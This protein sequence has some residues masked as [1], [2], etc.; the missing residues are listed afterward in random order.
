MTDYSS[1]SASYVLCSHNFK[2]HKSL[3]TIQDGSKLCH[4]WSCAILFYKLSRN[5]DFELHIASQGDHNSQ[6]SSV[7]VVNSLFCQG[8]PEA[9]A[10]ELLEAMIQGSRG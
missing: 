3:N 6:S 7:I 9:P 5:W 8:K 2:A 1:F 10:V 4:A